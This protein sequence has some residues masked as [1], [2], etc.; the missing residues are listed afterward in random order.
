MRV[1]RSVS[2][3]KNIPRSE[4][5]GPLG[6]SGSLPAILTVYSLGEGERKRSYASQ[7]VIVSVYVNVY[8]SE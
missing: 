7:C 8:T 4:A 2:E 6:G 5:P 3:E 1:V